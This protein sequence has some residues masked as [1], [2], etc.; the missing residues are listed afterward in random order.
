M[1]L[2]KTL[3]KIAFN[4]L[5][6]DGFNEVMIVTEPLTIQNYFPNDEYSQENY[7]SWKTAKESAID[8]LVEKIGYLGAVSE[9]AYPRYFEVAQSMSRYLVVNLDYLNELD[10]TLEMRVSHDSSDQEW[11]DALDN[12]NEVRL[13][14]LQSG[15]HLQSVLDQQ[16]SSDAIYSQSVDSRLE[17]F[18][19]RSD[20]L[21]ARARWLLVYVSIGAGVL[22]F[23]LSL[24]ITELRAYFD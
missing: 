16:V 3:K 6:Q 22:Y 21:L 5:I 20:A 8:S 10:T 9:S 18:E 15:S 11:Q 14:G 19:S 4:A 2:K 23:C 13:V 7:E 12:L 24:L 17:Q 1:R